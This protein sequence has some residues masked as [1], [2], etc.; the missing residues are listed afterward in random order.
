MKPTPAQIQNVLDDYHFEATCTMLDDEYATCSSFPFEL[1]QPV[2]DYIG[3]H[4]DVT[5]EDQFSIN[6]YYPGDEE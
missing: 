5:S 2:K 4:F 1:A 6:F 3:A